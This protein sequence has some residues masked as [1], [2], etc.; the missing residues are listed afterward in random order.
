[1]WLQ[2]YISVCNGKDKPMAERYICISNWFCKCGDLRRSRD[3]GVIVEHTG[4]KG[5]I[6]LKSNQLLSSSLEAAVS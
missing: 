4:K 5:K 1:M 6:G 3:A 2:M